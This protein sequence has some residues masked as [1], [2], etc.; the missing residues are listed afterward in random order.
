LPFMPF[1]LV[2]RS[3]LNHSLRKHLLE[4]HYQNQADL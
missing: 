2:L 4:E 3:S 1:Q